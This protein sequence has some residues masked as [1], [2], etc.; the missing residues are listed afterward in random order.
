MAPFVTPA[1]VTAAALYVLW[2]RSESKAR[3]LISDGI[4]GF[5]RRNPATREELDAALRLLEVVR[6][7]GR[8]AEDEQA[9]LRQ[10]E[11]ELVNLLRW[12]RLS[13][14]SAHAQAIFSAWMGADAELRA[15]LQAYVA[16]EASCDPQLLA[17][18]KRLSA[19]PQSHR[20]S[21]SARAVDQACRWVLF[22]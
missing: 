1:T 9:V 17:W 11:R 18:L 13:G 16:L 12:M 10:S 3:A 2:R 15:V 22:E 19:P 20:S 5:V 14:P 21:V 8:A 4:A 7:P 6:A